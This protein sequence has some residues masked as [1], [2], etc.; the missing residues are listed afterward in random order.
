MGYFDTIKFY[1]PKCQNEIIIQSKG[2][3][4]QGKGYFHPV[5]PI[6]V[7]SYVNG[8]ETTCKKCGKIWKLFTPSMVRVE[9]HPVEPEEEED[10]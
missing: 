5:V 1:C 4:C 2:G 7:A 6:D 9:L 8:E 10:E 3:E